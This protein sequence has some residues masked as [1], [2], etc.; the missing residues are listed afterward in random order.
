MLSLSS[1][2]QKRF[3][4]FSPHLIDS[5]NQMHAQQNQHNTWLTSSPSHPP[6]F[7]LFFMTLQQ[8][9]TTTNYSQHDQLFH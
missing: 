5:N 4:H 6:P 9:N 3:H 2:K 1:T 7:V 8:Q